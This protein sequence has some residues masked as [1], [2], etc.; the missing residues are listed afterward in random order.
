M[1]MIYHQPQAFA[2]KL[3]L[4]T[5]GVR[6]G[7]A[8]RIR[9]IANGIARGIL[10]L[11]RSDCDKFKA[12]LKQL[13]LLWRTGDTLLLVSERSTRKKRGR[14]VK[15]DSFASAQTGWPPYAGIWE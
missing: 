4:F 13:H 6:L 10:L 11:K 8:R 5:N 14:D 2:V 15:T 3:G 7:I 9:R 1:R 12:L